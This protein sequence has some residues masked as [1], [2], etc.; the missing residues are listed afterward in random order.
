MPEN[1]SHHQQHHKSH[2][3]NPQRRSP[4]RRKGAP[5][6][7]HIPQQNHLHPATAELVQ[8]RHHSHH[9]NEGPILAAAQR[10]PHQHEVNSLESQRDHLPANHPSRPAPQPVAHS[11]AFA[12]V[13]HLD[14]EMWERECPSTSSYLSSSCAV[15][16]R[17]S[18]SLSTRARPVAP[19]RA[20]TD[21]NIS[22]DSSASASA[23][24]SRF[25]TSSPV[26]PSTTSIPDP[27]NATTGTPI[28]CASSA[29]RHIPSA[30]PFAAT[31]LG[32]ATT[33]AFR[34]HSRTSSAEAAPTN[35]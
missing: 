13:P 31:T 26:S 28:A 15:C 10:P 9:A 35:S 16:L 30:S 18:N 22:S 25:R 6:A 8:H 12:G 32:T 33:A 20:A 7:A 2:S 1:H 4:C 14:F 27:R 11:K 19:I 17:R 34:I 24:E 29:T 23:S 21:S 5:V 3:R